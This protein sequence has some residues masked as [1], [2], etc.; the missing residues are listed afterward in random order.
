MFVKKTALLGLALFIVL[1][2]ILGLLV[3]SGELML[4]VVRGRSMIPL[5]RQG[6]IVFIVRTKPEEIKNGEIIVFRGR[7]GELIIHRVVDIVFINN[8]YY[9][10][11]KGDNNPGPDVWHFGNMPGIPFDKVVGKVVDINDFVLK[12]PYIGE[13]TLMFK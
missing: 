13:I 4:A 3:L 12:I 6:D 1:L 10:V 7:G 2:C 8:T 5:L 11:T 9:Y